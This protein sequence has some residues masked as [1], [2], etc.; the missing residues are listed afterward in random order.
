M[1]IETGV[2]R[3]YSRT[4]QFLYVGVGEHPPT[5]WADHRRN[6]DWW[7]E[8]DE[9][10]TTVQWFPTRD[11]ALTEETRAI[12]EEQP[13]YNRSGTLKIR[14]TLPG[15]YD[16]PTP[17][18]GAAEIQT[19]LGVSRQRVQQLV[20]NPGFPAPCAVLAMGKLWSTVAVEDWINRNR[21]A[22]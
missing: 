3:L 15:G 4:G 6:K 18:V 2:Y 21:L 7:S 16:L 12:T 17:W 13:A 14:K 11:L 8:V 1:D 19:A 22:A 20:R 9:T 5:R 10:R